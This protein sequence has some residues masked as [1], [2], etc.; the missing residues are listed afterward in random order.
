MEG[1]EGE[2]TV[3]VEVAS[4]QA[5]GGLHEV[6]GQRRVERSVA[7]VE[8][9]GQMLR[10]RVGSRHVGLTIAIEITGG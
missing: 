9:K 4:G 10:A 2:L 7:L 5:R 3:A 6:E 8:D 1:D